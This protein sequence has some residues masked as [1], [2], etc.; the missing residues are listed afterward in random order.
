MTNDRVLFRGMRVVADWPERLELAQLETTCF[1]L[2]IETPRIRYGDEGLDW[3]SADRPCH[4][5]AAI[6]GEFHVPGCDMERCP[7]CRG[8]LFACGCVP[9]SDDDVLLL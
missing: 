9:W 6:K 1:P 8:Q 4:D 7:S 2:G 3:G 5:C